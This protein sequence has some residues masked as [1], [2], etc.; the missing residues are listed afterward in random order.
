MKKLILLFLMG[1]TSVIT[2]QKKDKVLI[3]IDDEQI[4]VSEF[5]RVYE[6]NLDAIDNEEA[7]DLEKNL[8]L[9][10]NYK[11]KV[12]E[13]YSIKLDTLSSYV[14]EMKTYRNQLAAP[15]MQDSAYVSLLVK[16]AYFRTKNEVKAKHILIRT[17]KE[18]TPKDTLEAYQKIMKIRARILKGEDF[19]KVA[20]EVSEDE[21]SRTDVKSGRAGNRGNL[22][23]FSAFKMVY[24]FENAAYNTKKGDVSM[25]FRTRFGYH[26]LKVDG[27]RPSRGEVEVAHILITDKTAKGEEVINTVYNR[28]EKDEQ[29]KMLARKYSDDTGSKSKGG[30]LRRF[31]S[32]VM[33][34]PFDEVAFSLTKEGEYSKPF[35]T[36]FGWHI[37]QL[38]KKHPVQSFDEMKKELTSKIRSSDRLQLSEKAVVN[39]LK[40]EYQIEEFSD[41]KEIF[42]IVN[43]RNIANDS[44]QMKILEIN[45]K[46]YT[47]ADFVKYI[48]RRNN[49]PVFDLFNDFKDQEILEYYKN[50]LEK[51]E[52]DFAHI[53]Q[54]YEDGLLLFEL[55]QRKIWDKASK[56]TLGLKNYYSSNLK[57]YN[58][59]ELNKIKGEVMNDYQNHLE[60]LWITDLRNKTAIE[61]NKKQLKKL[62]KYYRKD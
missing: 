31:G 23:Y 61:V 11:L 2:A 1:L 38:I 40:K 43:L 15:Y 34:Q 37:I 36:R 44:L 26:I 42:N 8:D 13:A 39:K 19:E 41:A 62:I 54:E 28:L 48:K 14:K 7:K 59:K 32:G 51:T 29:F 27:F 16:D 25:P 57:K 35:R 30:K 60:Q 17:P 46:S 52:P 50:N 18:A 55:M 10:I 47:Q 56:D 9:F 20:E 58:N 33:V 6:K 49:K 4:M 22:G 24:P 5:K 12:K 21:S 3:T 45:E 53:L